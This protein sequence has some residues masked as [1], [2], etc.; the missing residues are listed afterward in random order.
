MSE[1][2]IGQ[3]AAEIVRLRNELA[4]SEEARKK[5]EE[6][7]ADARVDA[8]VHYCR[9]EAAEAEL[10]T[11][12]EQEPVYLRQFDKR[13]VQGWE[14]CSKT[15]Y[16]NEPDGLRQKLYAAPVPPAD[17]AELQKRIAELEHDNHNLN[18]ALGTDGYSQMFTPEEQA[19]ADAAHA[20][21][22]ERIVSMKKRG[23]RIEELERKLAEQQVQLVRHTSANGCNVAIPC[24]TEE[25]TKLIAQ[26]K[27]EQREE[28]AKICE[29]RH[30]TNGG[31]WF[32]YP[33]LAEAIRKG[34]KE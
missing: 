6:R 1:I 26:A 33:K 2:R 16:D 15:E 9:A 18:W 34:G 30:P 5:A 17:V 28:D 21:T 25:L 14:E 20:E 31:K 8:E 19:E 22:I 13:D 3:L 24:G 32:T 10:A 11:L 29:S 7:L 27:S 12:L 23:D 4:A